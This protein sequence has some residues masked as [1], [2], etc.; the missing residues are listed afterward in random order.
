MTAQ[1]GHQVQSGGGDL[2]GGEA[3]GQ[4]HGPHPSIPTPQIVL[5]WSPRGAPAQP[6]SHDPR[7]TLHPY[8]RPPRLCKLGDQAGRVGSQ[9]PSAAWVVA[10]GEAWPCGRGGPGSPTS[11]PE[12]AGPGPTGGRWEPALSPVLSQC[13]ATAVIM[14]VG[15]TYTLINYVSFINYLCYGVTILGLLVLR[16]RRPALHRPIKVRPGKDW[17][18]H[19]P[20][21][22]RD[23]PLPNW[24]PGAATAAMGKPAFAMCLALPGALCALAYS[25]LKQPCEEGAVDT[26]TSWTGK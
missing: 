2:A 7:Q 23:T 5:L 16:W 6:A 10:G 26:P 22:V 13:G 24:A 19:M 14:L 4:A 15:D 17:L 9:G 1:E 12:L 11:W 25:V 21:V 8:S 18:A 20:E 3:Q